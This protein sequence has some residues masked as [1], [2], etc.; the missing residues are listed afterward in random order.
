MW[1]TVRSAGGWRKGTGFRAN[2]AP[3][4]SSQEYECLEQEN[5]VLRREIGKLTEELKNLSEA[6]KEHVHVWGQRVPGKPLY[7]LLNFATNLTL[8]KKSVGENPLPHFSQL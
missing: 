6:L 4:L 5:T 3:F 8:L 7:L 2:F 1:P